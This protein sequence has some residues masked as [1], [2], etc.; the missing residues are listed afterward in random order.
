[1]N[2]KSVVWLWT[3]RR[4]RAG[5]FPARPEQ[6]WRRVLGP[7]ADDP[8]RSD[9]AAF[10]ELDPKCPHQGQYENQLGEGKLGADAGA[11][12]SAEGHVGE[13]GWW[14]GT[15]QKSCRIEGFRIV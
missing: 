5:G 14:R 2:R 11:G 9:R 12:A 10:G 7:G 1:S 4:G 13:P 3:K 6:K 15:V 8:D